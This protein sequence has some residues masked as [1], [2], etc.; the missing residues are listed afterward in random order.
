MV[1]RT[2]PGRK[3]GQI[4][5]ARDTATGAGEPS[6]RLHEPGHHAWLRVTTRSSG[7]LAAGHLVVTQRSPQ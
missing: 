6:W 7:R 5:D 3:R 2:C 4:P 1:E